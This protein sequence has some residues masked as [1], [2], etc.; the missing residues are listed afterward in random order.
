MKGAAAF[1]LDYLVEG[2]DGYLVSAP[3]TSPE[4]VYITSDGYHGATLYGGTADHAMIRELFLDLIEATKVLQTDDE[5][6]ARLESTLKKLYPYQIG[7]KG[8]LQE[9]YHDWEDD[10]PHHR[11]IS[12]LFSIYPGHSITPSTTPDLMK[13]ARRSL[14][15]RTN[16]GTGWSI[17]WKISLWARLLDGDMALDAIKKLFNYIGTE[18]GVQY[19]GGGTYPNLMD[20][21]PPFQIDGNFGGTAGIAEMLLQSHEGVIHLLPALPSE[22]KTGKV[23]GLRARG[24]VTVDIEWKDAKLVE[25]AITPDFDGSYMVKFG[26]KVQTVET[27]KGIRQTIKF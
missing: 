18:E 6:R 3:S 9:W 2:P 17:S 19:H 21:H 25:A 20:A 13:A 23:T 11:H 27:K 10:D 16:N 7:K 24:A 5:L 22:W 4:N 8:N 15:L 12:H 14:E 1:C 26:D